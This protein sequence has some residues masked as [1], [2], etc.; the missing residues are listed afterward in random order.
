[1]RHK[2]PFLQTHFNHYTDIAVT[3]FT[4]VG[5]TEIHKSGP[6]SAAQI[7][8]SSV[9]FLGEKQEYNPTERGW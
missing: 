8:C 2:Q 3:E 7:F 5:S 9:T 1:M 4:S 6:L